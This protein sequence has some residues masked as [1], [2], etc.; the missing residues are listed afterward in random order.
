MQMARRD[1]AGTVLAEVQAIRTVR[2]SVHQEMSISASAD[3]VSTGD[4]AG[5][6]RK[7]ERSRREQVASER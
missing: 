6:I 7:Q 1:R 3:H 2:W 4:D 5:Q